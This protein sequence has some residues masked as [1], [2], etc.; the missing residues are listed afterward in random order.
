[1]SDS[2]YLWFEIISMVVLVGI[3]LA[4]VLIIFKRPHIPSAKESTA[5][6]AF[7]AVLAIIFGIILWQLFGADKAT[8]FYAGWLTEY[9]LSIDNLF[10]FVI[11]MSRFSVP[12]KYQQEVLMV[13]VV[14]ALI[15]RGIFI[16]VGAALIESFSAVFYIFGA[17]LLYTAY[18]Q[19][20]RSAESDEETE[21]KL[22]VWLRKRITVSKD[23]DGAK[24]RTS[25]DGKRMFT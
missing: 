15:L 19:A 9:S 4:D 23:F 8:E 6:V 22:I 1:M 10:V 12:K 17:F 14:L 5:W 20:F 3:L 7:Y 24:I 25:V 11:I 18:H 13:G 21:S 2:A 16:L